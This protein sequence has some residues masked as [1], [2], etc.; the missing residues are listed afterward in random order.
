M[1]AR[2]SAPLLKDSDVV[3]EMRDRNVLYAAAFDL[4]PLRDAYAEITARR[5]PRPPL[6]WR[7]VRLNGEWQ[8][9]P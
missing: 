6:A 7:G 1:T 5:A 4:M 3:H 9:R 2:Y 8:Q